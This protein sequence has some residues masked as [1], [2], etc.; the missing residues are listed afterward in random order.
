MEEPV[1]A[2]DINFNPGPTVFPSTAPP[3]AQA[4]ELPGSTLPQPG[5]YHQPPPAYHNNG[6]YQQNPHQIPPTRKKIYLPITSISLICHNIF[7]INMAISY[8]YPHFQKI[9]ESFIQMEG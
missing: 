2:S 3:P 8:I 5:L 7:K 4:G 9:F 1:K 6:F